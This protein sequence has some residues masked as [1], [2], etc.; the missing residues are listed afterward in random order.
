[1]T[2]TLLALLAALTVDTTTCPTTSTNV[3]G[4][5]ASTTNIQ[6]AASAGFASATTIKLSATGSWHLV[7]AIPDGTHVT[8]SPAAPSAPTTG[9]LSADCPL[10]QITVSGVYTGGTATQNFP[11][12]VKCAGSGTVVYALVLDESHSLGTSTGVPVVTAG[13]PTNYSTLWT[14]AAGS[15]TSGLNGGAAIYWA[16]CSGAI[17]D[18]PKVTVTCTGGTSVCST[19]VAAGTMETTIFVRGFT[20]VFP[21]PGNAN[22]ANS[23]AGTPALAV[24]T[25]S[26]DKLLM[27]WSDFS[28]LS[29]TQTLTS[30]AALTG[31]ASVPGPLNVG[32]NGGN[33]DYFVGEWT[34]GTTGAGS[35]TIGVTAPTTARGT[36]TTVEVCD[37]TAT[38]CPNGSTPTA[39]PAHPRRTLLGYGQ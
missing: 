35:T 37:S 31:V 28:S 17:T 33:D 26:G 25:S 22:A 21:T 11:V 30:G 18:T 1:M 27:G 29:C 32:C 3:A 38:T 2:F 19:G 10:E 14:L 36:W 39:L 8:I 23:T 15:T 12:P 7:T 13:T 24:T 5:N 9:T 4:T 6:V 20:A 16:V 34:S